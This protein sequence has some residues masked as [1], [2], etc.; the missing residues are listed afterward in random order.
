MCTV[1][2][3]N[4]GNMSGS[5][6]ERELLWEHK[7]QVSVSTAISSSPKLH[8]CFYN[9]IETQRTCFLF[10]LENIAIK[11]IKEKKLV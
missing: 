9:S 4:Y 7:P 10:L 1:F 6:G 2:L 8:Q 3:S 11:L 5:L